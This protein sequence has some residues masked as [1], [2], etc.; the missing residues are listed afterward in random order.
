M[1]NIFSIAILFIFTR[2]YSQNIEISFGGGA[3][4]YGNSLQPNREV[5]EAASFS[6]MAGI[7]C[8]RPW[9]RGGNEDWSLEA[10]AGISYTH[11]KGLWIEDIYYTSLTT[12][13]SVEYE[14]R[15]RFDGNIHVLG[16]EITPFILTY[17]QGLKLRSSI[18][19]GWNISDKYDYNRIVNTVVHENG[20]T[21][22]Y[23]GGPERFPVESPTYVLHWNSRL[24]YNIHFSE[25]YIA[26]FYQC[27]LGLLNEGE[28][29]YYEKIISYRHH[30]GVTFGMNRH[31]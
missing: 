18:F 3:G 13:G 4:N 22:Y 17:R 8:I 28:S 25:Y 27:S 29:L 7:T 9:W 2:A 31:Q 30:F 5:F 14:E 12:T 15:H 6:P 16:A 10:G 20:Q 19:L 1:R 23:D 26:P 24:S 11:Y 21:T